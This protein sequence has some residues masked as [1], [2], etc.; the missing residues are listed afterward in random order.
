[1]NAPNPLVLFDRSQRSY[2]Q[3]V[4]ELVTV[5]V[6]LFRYGEVVGEALDS[7]AAQTHPRL[8]LLIVD[9]QSQDGSAGVAAGWLEANADRFERARLLQPPANIGLSGVRNLAFEHAGSDAV[10]VLDADNV[11]MPRAIGTLHQAL[12]A[13]QAAAAYSQ[14]V[15]FGAGEGIGAADVW[16]PARFRRDNYVDAMA[17][18]RLSAWRAVGGYSQ[19]E[20]GWE[21][22]DFWCKFV[23]AG[24]EGVFVPELLCRYRVHTASMLRTDTAAQRT[25][26]VE[27]MMTRHPWLHLRA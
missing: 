25:R 20:Y 2:P 8:E 5:A 18:V 10:F 6:S 4:G 21:D 14:L 9:D 27:T 17:L 1:M 15:F 22:Y 26:L 24:L 7:V 12:W 3:P 23:E 19:L 11:L 13:S 16:D